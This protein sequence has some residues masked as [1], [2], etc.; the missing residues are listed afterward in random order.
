MRRTKI[1]GTLGPATRDAQSLRALLEAGVD[2]V[3]LNL[4]HPDPPTHLRAGEAVRKEADQLGREIAIL[5]DLPGPKMRTG[6]IAGDEVALEAGQ[7]F[8]LSFSN[9][10]GDSAGV[11]TT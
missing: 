1:V 8:T 7:S 3:R 11:G 4:A 9:T 5:A 10:V 2:V 6:S